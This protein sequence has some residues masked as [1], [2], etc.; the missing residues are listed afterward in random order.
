MM[1]NI[2]QYL[3][4]FLWLPAQELSCAGKK[5]VLV[6]ETFKSNKKK[7]ASAVYLSDATLQIS[8]GQFKQILL[9]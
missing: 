1:Y 9:F 3:H 8:I 5:N 7:L 4:G 6:F 2:I